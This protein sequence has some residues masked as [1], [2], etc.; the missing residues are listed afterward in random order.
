MNGVFDCEFIGLKKSSCGV[1]FECTFLLLTTDRREVSCYHWHINY[2]MYSY[3]RDMWRNTLCVINKLGLYDRVISPFYDEGKD[4]SVVQE[5]VREICSFFYV[6]ALY[7]KGNVPTDILLIDKCKSD[8]T[9]FNLED[10]NCEKFPSKIHN[11][12]DEVRFFS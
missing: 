3:N 11:P 2:N 6:T 8:I 1:I 7:A 12:E 5:E 10:F 9:I 4:L